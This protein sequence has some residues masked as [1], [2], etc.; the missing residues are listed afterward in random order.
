MP[1]EEKERFTTTIN[2]ELLRQV[3]ILA[4]NE[5]R[6]TNKLIEEGLKDLLKKYEKKT[7]KQSLTARVREMTVNQEM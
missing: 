4:I 1:M 3:R 5:K 2:G 7:K 6:T